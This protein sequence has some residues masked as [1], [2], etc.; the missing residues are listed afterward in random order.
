M[1]P[2]RAA[3]G[4][5]PHGAPQGTLVTLGG[6]GFS[7]SEDGSSDIDDLLLELTGAERPRV[8]FLPTASEDDPGYSGRFEAAFRGRARTQVL[9]LLGRVPGAQRDPRCLLDQD[10]IYVGGGSTV[11][12]LAQWRR[13]GL[14]AIL[15]HAAAEGVVL[16]GISAGMN[17]WFAACSTDS[18]GPLAPLHDGLGVLPGAACPHYHGEPDR[19]PLLLRWITEGRMGRTWAVDDGAALVWRD[20]ELVD[21]VAEGSGARAW[22]VERGPASG[23][24][25][26]R[27]DGA[28][29]D[30]ERAASGLPAVAVE[31]ELPVRLLR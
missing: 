30:D 12:L 17:C 10:L 28:A 31:R 8:C 29:G 20:G 7:M 21:A 22:L 13:H 6:G 18:Y 1:S 23:V 2:A 16:A 26:I 4:E 25:G 27:R 19:R 14:P 11:E 3:V 9:S 24:E 15:A 5:T